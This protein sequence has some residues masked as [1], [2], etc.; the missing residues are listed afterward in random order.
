MRTSC[1]PFL[2]ATCLL[3]LACGDAGT[4]T[5]T[6]TP[7]G[8]GAGGT[9][10]SG[11]SAGTTVDGGGG[12][13]ASGGS[14]GASPGGSGGDTSSGGAPAGGGGAGG[15]TGEPVLLAQ[16]V[17]GEYPTIRV[18]KGDPIAD[19]C[20][21]LRLA[22][23]G[24]GGGDN[25]AYA[26]VSRPDGWGVEYALI[27]KGFADCD[28]FNKATENELEAATSASGS[29]AWDGGG[30]PP[31]PLDVDVTMTFPAVKPWSVPQD[32]IQATDLPAVKW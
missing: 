13:G 3:S 14:G 17:D 18:F 11:G 2:V 5:T 4:G 25:P 6:G 1:L 30:W 28:D 24:M 32:T 26:A 7:G 16:W 31:G 9:G 19:R 22:M 15:A 27:T 21:L 29:V 12:A 20:T 23:L 10:A 8:G